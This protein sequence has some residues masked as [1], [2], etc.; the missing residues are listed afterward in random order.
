MALL[1]L[2]NRTE[3][4]MAL[5]R[6]AQEELGHAEDKAVFISDFPWQTNYLN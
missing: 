1:A 3:T 2:R 4:N 6:C 5:S